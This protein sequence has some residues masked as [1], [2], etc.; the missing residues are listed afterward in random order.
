MAAS[1]TT[2]LELRRWLR[3][4]WE[5]TLAWA[6]V[7]TALALILIG[8]R[9]LAA[10]P[11]GTEEVAYL[12]SG[13][14]GA[15]FLVVVAIGLLLGADANDNL[16]KLDRIE[17][18][19]HGRPVPEH[20]QVLA[21]LRAGFP[22]VDVAT[23]KEG[24]GVGRRPVLVSSALLAVAVA[25]IAAGWMRAAGTT[26][27]AVAFDGLVIALAGLLL[28]SG[29]VAVQDLRV[30]NRLA[31]RM[32]VLFEGILQVDL[33]PT[34]PEAAGDRAVAWTAPGLRRFHRSSCPALAPVSGTRRPVTE[35]QHHFEACLICHPELG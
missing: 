35:D 26:A 11:L 8:H 9:H 22:S 25:V 20:P 30:R 3:A 16:R 34:V 14:F 12:I 29:V 24:G 10:S 18:A 7:A 23:G 6:L 2:R 15:L 21:L 32:R 19:I 5:R 27:L 31:R 33:A 28:A 17:W 1:R 4:E 13:G